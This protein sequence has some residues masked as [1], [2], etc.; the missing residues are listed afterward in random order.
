MLG[1][2]KL[3]AVPVNVNFR[4]VTARARVSVRRCGPEVG[5][6]RARARRGRPAGCQECAECEARVGRGC[7]LRSTP[8]SIVAQA[9]KVGPNPRRP[10][11]ALYRWHDRHAQGRHVA[12][13]RCPARVLWHRTNR[14]SANPSRRDPRKQ[15]SRRSTTPSQRPRCSAALKPRSPDDQRPGRWLCALGRGTDC[16]ARGRRERRRAARLG[17]RMTRG[18]ALADWASLNTG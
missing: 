5:R 7:S 13:R 11:Y 17:R 16:G 18:R 3:G 10:V 9:S 4:Y 15:R 2:W 6:D 1:A 12:P 8:A 14:G